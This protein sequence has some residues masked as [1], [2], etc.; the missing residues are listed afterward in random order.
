MILGPYR[1]TIRRADGTRV[2]E[3]R[4][5]SRFRLASINR[6]SGKRW[7]KGEQ[8]RGGTGK[9]AIGNCKGYKN[10]LALRRIAVSAFPNIN[11]DIGDNLCVTTG[12]PRI[13]RC[14]LCT[15]YQTDVLFGSLHGIG[16]RIFGLQRAIVVEHRDSFGCWNE[17]GARLGG[18]PRHKCDDGLLRG[19][20]VSRWEQID[21]GICLC[22]EGNKQDSQ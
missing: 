14:G 15:R 16:Y 1:L 12:Q 6:N 2:R 8:L 13:A 3:K 7:A 22:A 5:L 4:L 11:V 18:G 9:L 17:F 10:E 20:L 19:A 21:V